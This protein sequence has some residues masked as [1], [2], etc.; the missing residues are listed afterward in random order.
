MSSELLDEL[1]DESDLRH[2]EPSPLANQVIV[3]SSQ[4]DGTIT[5]DVPPPIILF[6]D[7]NP[8]TQDNVSSAVYEPLFSEGQEQQS[9][10]HMIPPQ[11]KRPES[12]RHQFPSQDRWEDGPTSL[13]LTAVVS[14]PEL[15]AQ[16]MEDKDEIGSA[17]M[18]E[19]PETEAQRKKGVSSTAERA[20]FLPPDIEHGTAFEPKD[21]NS[22]NVPSR[23]G[24]PPRFPSSDIWEDSPDSARLETTVS[25]DAPQSLQKEE[26]PPRTDIRTAPEVPERP[27]PAIPPR[28]AAKPSIAATVAAFDSPE[29]K[30]KPKVPSRP[31]GGK[32]AA[33]QA[34]F[35]SDLNSRL[36]LG[37]QIPPK[38]TEERPDSLDEISIVSAPLED[39][40]KGRV[41]GPI[42]RK[43]ATN[44]ASSEPSQSTDN[45][46]LCAS[47]LVF[48][49][50]EDGSL[51]S[52][53]PHTSR[54]N[55]INESVE[56]HLSDIH[57]K[58]NDHIFDENK[59]E[60]NKVTNDFSASAITPAAVGFSGD[61]PEP[62]IS[63]ATQDLQNDLQPELSAALTPAESDVRSQGSD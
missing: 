47:R 22:L 49:I 36:Q 12:L 60:E 20:S 23:P 63:Q 50:D 10:P 51:T 45:L 33:L 24:L 15:P 32:I 9:L 40:R 54:S 55:T 37:P 29:M 21:A 4:E 3:R 52:G 59:M 13:N 42:R 38:K 58:G 2:H 53:A 44:E 7:S 46:C 6:P 35:M 1:D 26:K 19:L 62:S 41:R 34:G 18:F 25:A 27:K 16:T 5:R 56:R 17:G 61:M 28:P 30:P 39:S 57:N 43:V 8:P 48:S 14:T 11:E 31:V